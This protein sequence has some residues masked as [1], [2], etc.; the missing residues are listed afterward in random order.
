LT[1]KVAILPVVI[2]GESAG[3]ART[4]CGGRDDMLRLKLG[5]DAPTGSKLDRA[6]F[7]TCHLVPKTGT[8]LRS[9]Q[10][11]CSMRAK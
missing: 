3:I 7:F 11:V 5:V 6:P 4:V 8:L 10:A 1:L 2:V 9:E